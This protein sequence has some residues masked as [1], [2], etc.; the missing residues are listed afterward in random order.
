MTKKTDPAISPKMAVNTAGLN[1]TLSPE[2]LPIKTS[3]TLTITL[4][5]QLGQAITFNPADLSPPINVNKIPFT[6]MID[7][8]LLTPDEFGQITVSSPITYGNGSNNQSTSITTA[9][10]T[11]Y[12]FNYLC[13]SPTSDVTLQEGD[14]LTITLTNVDPS[15][16][17]VGS[18]GSLTF[19]YN[20]KK[21]QGGGFQN[22]VGNPLTLINSSTNNP[23]LLDHLEWS[24][25]GGQGS[26]SD[27]IYVSDGTE[28]IS[29]KLTLTLSNK[30]GSNPLVQD[31]VSGP[32]FMISFVTTEEGGDG[33]VNAFGTVSDVQNIVIDP[34]IVDNN[35]YGWN[36]PQKNTQGPVPTWTLTP[37]STNT[38]IFGPQGSMNI[39]IDGI[40][41]HTNS[42]YTN[43][44]LSYVNI[45]GYEDGSIAIPVQKTDPVP[46]ISSFT[47]DKSS[48]EF[49]ETINFNSK[50]FG[51]AQWTLQINDPSNNKI[52]YN[53]DLS[54]SQVENIPVDFL[55]RLGSQLLSNLGTYTAKLSNTYGN[56]ITDALNFT[57]KN[58]CTLAL[59]SFNIATDTGWNLQNSSIN[60]NWDAPDSI[61]GEGFALNLL[62]TAI[63]NGQTLETPFPINLAS[64]VLSS[65]TGTNVEIGLSGNLE[66]LQPFDS[67]QQL[68][69]SLQLMYNETLVQA[70]TFSQIITCPLSDLRAVGGCISVDSS[71]RFLPYA[72][73]ISTQWFPPASGEGIQVAI[74]SYNVLTDGSW[75][76]YPVTY[77]VDGSE[78]GGK[79]LSNLYTLPNEQASK[80]FLIT[81][82]S[83]TSAGNL[84]S[85]CLNASPPS[86]SEGACIT[87]P[88]FK[89]VEI[90]SPT[91]TISQSQFD[92]LNNTDSWFEFTWDIPPEGIIEG[93]T[94]K[95]FF[96]TATITVYTVNFDN[97]QFSLLLNSNIDDPYYSLWP[98]NS[99]SGSKTLY[100][101]LSDSDAQEFTNIECSSTVSL[102]VKLNFG[103][104][105]Q[106]TLTT[107]MT[108]ATICSASDDN[109]SVVWWN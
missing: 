64:K 93:I 87:N 52:Y 54:G 66:T 34:L 69:F 88:S 83:N 24:I 86:D 38:G 78:Y 90:P 84:V 17:G 62:V 2:T 73:Y 101:R 60:I 15:T 30:D 37:K 11:S 59:N 14:Q 91:L 8:S 89:A 98:V 80:T 7:L 44:Y 104:I 16:N 51:A 53:S 23:S 42:G 97:K 43:I 70:I 36:P 61:P 1:V 72:S 102:D 12:G 65:S 94:I 5:N 95:N 63:N 32:Q 3:S 41:S 40:V 22:S 85:I 68:T 48:Y 79:D 82:L 109:T 39:P 57:I 28:E 55:A 77:A 108:P 27:L 49:F 20:G 47:T 96:I 6:V 105:N 50:V 45:G 100:M 46:T 67:K 71:G 19:G 33:S 35:N 103:N 13:I 18:S 4:T 31:P 107:T 81:S 76:Y 106:T 92:N 10:T 74:G 29:N 26:S 21:S 56:V 58:T 99:L 25:S 75:Q 9:F